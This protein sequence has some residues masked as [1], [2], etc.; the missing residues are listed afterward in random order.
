MIWKIVLVTFHRLD[1]LV[2]I[3]KTLSVGHMYTLNFSLFT[4]KHLIIQITS[5]QTF[6]FPLHQLAT[7]TSQIFLWYSNQRPPYYACPTDLLCLK[8]QPS[9]RLKLNS[10]ESSIQEFQTLDRSFTLLEP[11]QDIWLVLVIQLHIKNQQHYT[12]IELVPFSL[13]FLGRYEIIIPGER[14][15]CFLSRD[16]AELRD[17]FQEWYTKTSILV[18]SF[19]FFLISTFKLYITNPL[20]DS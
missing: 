20:S 14:V 8:T 1:L 7:F 10:S 13:G 4:S 6:K 17:A 16:I 12:K 2:H 19:A 15:A 11:Q 5:Q 3:T 18:N 9:S